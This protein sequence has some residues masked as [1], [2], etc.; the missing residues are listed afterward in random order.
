MGH[1]HRQQKI[2]H[3]SAVWYSGSPLQLDFGE[4][5]DQKGVLVVDAEP[6][7]PAKVT[8][9]PITSGRRLVTLRGTF[10]QVT[11]RAEEAE[12]AYVKVELVEKARVGLADEIRARIPG[13]VDVVLASAFQAGTSE[14]KA[15]ERLN[16]V[17]AFH[18][19]LADSGAEDER[20]EALFAEL[21]AEVRP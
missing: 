2:P 8:A 1:L 20:V 10:D 15:R 17:D 18:A 12:G 21:L 16:P 6:G 7:L 19:Y 5:D 11:E 14:H 9:V 13:V 3:S 4:V